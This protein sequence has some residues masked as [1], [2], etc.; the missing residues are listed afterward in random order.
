MNKLDRFNYDLENKRRKKGKRKR[1]T[2]ARSL[3]CWITEYSFHLRLGFASVSWT[4]Q[5]LSKQYLFFLSFHPFFCIA[6]V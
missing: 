2:T 6:Y 1:K 5:E 4:N 3:E